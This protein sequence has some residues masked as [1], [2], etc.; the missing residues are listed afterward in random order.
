MADEVPK[1]PR[2]VVLL[3]GGLDSSTAL[4]I[5]AER[6]FETYA[7]SFRY[8]QRHTRELEAARQVAE[9]FGCR[10]W[11]VVDINLAL[12]GGSALTDPA[13]AVPLD[14]DEEQ[15]GTGVPI[16]Y[17]PA[18][19]LVFLSIATAYA[20]TLGA[21]DVF[22]GINALDYS[23]SGDSKVWI[24][25]SERAQLIP[26][27]DFWKLPEGDYQ[28]MA[29]DPETLQVVWRRV[30]A[31]YQHESRGKR[32][33]RITLERGQQITIT[34]DHSLF[35]IDETSARLMPIKGSSVTRGTPIVTP[36]DLSSCAEAWSG[37]LTGLNLRGVVARRV[38]KRQSLVIRDGYVTNRLNQVRVPVDLPITDDFLYV[39]GLW[40]AEGGKS[41]EA[42]KSTL[43][44]S[45]G[46]IPG[47]V[48]TLKKVFGAYNVTVAR[49]S[50]NE[51]DYSV[52]SSVFDAVFHHW[53]LLGTAHQG[54]KKFPTFFWSLS[55]RQRRILVAGLWDGDGGHVFNGEASIAQKS[56]RLIEDLYHCLVVDGIFPV[57]KKA[58]HNQKVLVLGRAK[59]FRAFARLYPL[60]HPSKR[61]SLEAAGTMTGKDK[62]TG[63]WT[64]EGLWAAVSAAILPAGS[65]TV[66]YNYGGKYDKSVRAQRS[67][68]MKVSA[69]QHLAMSKL[70]FL[71]VIDIA[72]TAE[73]HMYD[74]SVEGAENFVANGILAHNSG[75]PDC[76]PEFL[77]AFT[78]AAN[79]ATKAGTEDQRTLCY[80]A[81][82]IAL[83]KADIV[84]EGT[85]LG[86]PWELTWSCYLGGERACGR[87][88]SCQ[89]RLKGFAE[90]GMRDPVLYETDVE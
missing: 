56:H 66:I 29:V 71:R 50:S 28:T 87:C 84:R 39:I 7:L 65:K 82:L 55:L 33:F 61:A 37:D 1:P 5:A 73:E 42:D 77:D 68:F 76:R 4:A 24:R 89:L 81:P 58:K 18:R 26:I 22:L 86:V 80:H 78:Q 15:I 13:L 59:D 34:E 30:T 51:F 69:L 9:H 11:Q 48:A 36:F 43:S 72:E 88:D 62:V 12:F 49:S 40:L 90:A 21:N 14:R 20:E 17:V 46:G 57:V 27:K 41:P 83:S 35:S 19:N 79:L 8:G 2:A 10:G 85:R 64:C 53:G 38:E 47:A 70:A 60:R 75:Y 6:G 67:A 44:F 23:V 45:V 54:S 16:T 63:L 74:L 25:S 52:S 31:R 3:S 32:C